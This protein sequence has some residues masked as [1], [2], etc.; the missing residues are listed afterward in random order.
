MPQ[1][2]KKP[3]PILV[4]ERARETPDRTYAIIPKS[5]NLQDGF[6]N[7]TYN[8][9]QKAIDSMSWWLDQNLGESV[10][11][12]TIAYMGASDLRY[13]F[14]Y[15]A[16][17]KTRRKVLST[18]PFLM[19]GLI[20][21]QILLPLFMNSRQAQ[22]SLLKSTNCQVLIAS[23]DL[24][25][26]WN[27]LSPEVDGFKI[28]TMP[29]FEHFSNDHDVVP[30]PFTKT[31][32]EVKHDPIYIAQTSGTTGPFFNAAI[33]YGTKLLTMSQACQNQSNTL[34]TCSPFGATE[35]PNYSSTI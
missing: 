32:D 16:A 23:T 34:V 24:V 30:Y 6:I 17:I 2:D 29:P 3:Y 12:E 25:P 14:L 33:H 21:L 19:Y 26:H 20:T 15:V 8:Q 1:V 18:L 10:I 13:L 22:L 7:F 4:E 5:D 35:A 9:L 11:L 31:W 28:L 27:S